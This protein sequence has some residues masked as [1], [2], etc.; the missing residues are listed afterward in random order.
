MR[1]SPPNA[2]LKAKFV[3]ICVYLVC[4]CP[5]G[6][7]VIQDH[8]M[9]VHG[10]D[11]LGTALVLNVGNSEKEGEKNTF[12]KVSA[13]VY[14][15]CKAT[16]REVF[17]LEKTHSQRSVPWYMSYV[18]PQEES[19]FFEK[20]TFSKVSALVYVLCKPTIRNF[21]FSKKTHSQR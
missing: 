2:S 21:F 15:L 14:V 13:L 8:L 4:H 6:A 18:N 19:F 11:G 20:N 12:S 3:S 1:A 10:R 7:R 9:N 17:F 5:L 16:R